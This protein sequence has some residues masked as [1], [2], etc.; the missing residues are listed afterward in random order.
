VLVTL[1]ARFADGSV[2]VLV[3]ASGDLADG[4]P[5]DLGKGFYAVVLAVPTDGGGNW[6]AQLTVPASA[7]VGGLGQ[8]DAVCG[9]PRIDDTVVFYCARGHFQITGPPEPVAVQ[10]TFTG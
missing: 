8:L 2:G 9:D 6:S 5:I 10:P 4:R 1:P 3:A 7:G